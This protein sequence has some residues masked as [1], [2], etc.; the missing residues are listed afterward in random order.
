M[1]N[2]RGGTNTEILP[3][4]L[5]LVIFVVL[6]TKIIVVLARNQYL[7]ANKGGPILTRILKVP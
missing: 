1:S 5:F 7:A 3:F 4:R 6:I 2:I